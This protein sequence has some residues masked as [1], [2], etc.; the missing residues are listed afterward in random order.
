[1]ANR[2]ETIDASGLQ[3]LLQRGREDQIIID[4]RSELEREVQGYIEGSH[5][6]EECKANEASE[7]K[8]RSTEHIL[9]IR[10]K[11]FT[12][13]DAQELIQSLG[14]SASKYDD[15]SGDLRELDGNPV[16]LTKTRFVHFDALTTL[17]NEGDIL[18][19]DVRN[20]TEL[21][22]VGQIQGSVC[23][24]LH[25]IP[26]AFTQL[27]DEAFKERYGFKKPKPEDSNNIILT[28]RSGRR[29]LVA[30]EKMMPLGFENL[31]IYSGSFND[32]SK[33]NGDA[34]KASFDLD[35]DI[36]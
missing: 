1:M 29:V 24:P 18:L 11:G 26:L 12:K 34:F 17:L 3:E 35:Y 27:N 19:L 4:C 30:D 6:Y 28:C 21:N 16:A 14:L 20:R 7:L 15:F 10:G 33:N 2:S 25:E 13:K 32:W 31:R 9:C 22:E 23:V 8:G 36:L 5:W